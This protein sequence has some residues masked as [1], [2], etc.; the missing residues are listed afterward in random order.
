MSTVDDWRCAVHN[1]RLIVTKG[2]LLCR[3]NEEYHFF[4]KPDEV[5]RILRINTSHYVRTVDGVYLRNIKNPI[6]ISD[7]DSPL[8]ERTKRGMFL[9][10]QG[11]LADDAMRYWHLFVGRVDEGWA[12]CLVSGVLEDADS[13][14]PGTGRPVKSGIVTDKDGHKID[15]VLAASWTR[16]PDDREVAMSALHTRLKLMEGMN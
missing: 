14:I 9:R 12:Q 1:T 7:S 5:Q 2:Q 6:V 3:W 11:M 10:L 4:I 8:M 16:E 15:M 13:V